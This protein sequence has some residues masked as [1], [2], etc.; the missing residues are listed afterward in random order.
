[1]LE[2]FSG[3][4]YV[5]IMFIMGG[6]LYYFVDKSN[7]KSLKKEFEERKKAANCDAIN[8]IDAIDRYYKTVTYTKSPEFK[9]NMREELKCLDSIESTIDK[10]KKKEN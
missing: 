4:L 8:K 10:L 9:A 1:M 7:E 2:I 6:L 5:G 3:L